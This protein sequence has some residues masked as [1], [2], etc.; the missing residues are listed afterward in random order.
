MKDS[1]LL[2]PN[3][4]FVAVV[5]VKKFRSG[6]RTQ[7]GSVS[8]C[9]GQRFYPPDYRSVT[10]PLSNWLNSLEKIAAH[11][12]ILFKLI[13]CISLLEMW[14]FAGKLINS[15]VTNRFRIEQLYNIHIIH[16][17]FDSKYFHSK[18]A[19]PHS[20]LTKST[21]LNITCADLISV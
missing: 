5:K 21:S 19:T 20:K 6:F 18:H 4:K 15:G 2:P 3:F 12:R 8:D 13:M 1:K 16:R 7:A 10:V 14:F 11:I 17:Q 9:I